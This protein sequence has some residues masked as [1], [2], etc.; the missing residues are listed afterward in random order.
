M[1]EQSPLIVIEVKRIG[2]TN[3]NGNARNNECDIKNGLAQVLEQAFCR[4]AELAVFVI[5]D[6]GRGADREWNEEEQAYV[7]MFLQ[8]NLGV[9]LLVVRARFPSSGSYV[10]F[11]RWPP[12]PESTTQNGE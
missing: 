12:A 9:T 3:K 6:G 8:N 10:Q 11:E 2:F 4:G 1:S 7:Q 5:L